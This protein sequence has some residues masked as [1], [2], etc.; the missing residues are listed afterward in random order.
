MSL[1][2]RIWHLRWECNSPPTEFRG[3]CSPFMARIPSD[4]LSSRGFGRFEERTD[5]SARLD[6]GYS[7]CV[8]ALVVTRKWRGRRASSAA[9][10]RKQLGIAGTEPSHGSAQQLRRRVSAKWRGW[11]EVPCKGCSTCSAASRR[12]GVQRQS[13]EERGRAAGLPDCQATCAPEAHRECGGILR[14]G[15]RCAAGWPVV[16]RAQARKF[17]R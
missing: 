5:S 9:R 2:F 1:S 4:L 11:V 7:T 16:V 10:Q 8:E 15:R 12:R 13:R 6:E 17:P 3:L 14:A